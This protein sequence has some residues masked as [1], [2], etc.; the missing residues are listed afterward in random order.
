MDY[1]IPLTLE[2]KYI[3]SEDVTNILLDMLKGINDMSVLKRH[4]IP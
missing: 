3:N 4:K 1:R 2:N